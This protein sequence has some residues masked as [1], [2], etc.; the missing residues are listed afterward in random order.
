[1]QTSYQRPEWEDTAEDSAHI[2]EI[3]GFSGD[4]KGVERI[5]K[6]IRHVE[7]LFRAH[8]SS[9]YVCFSHPA[10][11]VSAQK[12]LDRRPNVEGTSHKGFLTK[13]FLP[14]PYVKLEDLP[15]AKRPETDPTVAH[16]MIMRSV[17]IK[18][19]RM[20]PEERAAEEEK[21]QKRQARQQ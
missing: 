17:G 11:K 15:R 18:M 16:R 12:L 7:M 8:E 21:R 1:M 20:T 5:L 14:N 4:Q 19:A 6:G 3:Y 10:A 13:P 9:Y 2:L